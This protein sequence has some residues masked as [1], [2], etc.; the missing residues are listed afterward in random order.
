MKK[1]LIFL[2]IFLALVTGVAFAEENVTVLINGEPLVSDVPAQK[3]PVYDEKGDY[4]GDRVMLPLRAVAEK[5]NCDVYWNEESEGITLYRKGSLTVMWIDKEMA[6]SLV[7]SGVYDHY[8]M[9]VPPTL[10][11]DRTMVPVRATAELLGASVNWIEEIQTVAI[12]LPMNEWE[13]NQGAAEQ[14]G[15][16]EIFLGMDYEKISSHYLGTS[17]RI[18]GTF[19]LEDEREIKF[20]LYPQVAPQTVSRFVDCAKEGLYDDTIFHRVI[21]GF[22][23]QGGGFDQTLE[24]KDKEEKYNSLPGEF[25]ANNFYNFMVHKRGILSM[26]RTNDLNGGG[27]QFFICHQDALHLDGYYAAFGSITEGMEI[28]D[29]ICQTETDENDI[30]ITPIIVKTVVIDEK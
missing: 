23:A 26:A 13:E 7:S 1:F 24:P 2:G 27:T 4:L 6:F 18:T 5:L 25:L 19:V 20:E 22:M 29:E 3:I 16:Y 21:A 14:Y 15:F 12:T 10:T 11:E 8:V 30:P 28:V 9:D 17:D